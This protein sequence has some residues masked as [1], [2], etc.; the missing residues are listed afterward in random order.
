MWL[1][2]QAETREK[3][4]SWEK[5]LKE[6]AKDPIKFLYSRRDIWYLSEAEKKALGLTVWLEKKL[7]SI[8]KDLRWNSSFISNPVQIIMW[9][10]FSNL[11]YGAWYYTQFDK[12]VD[13]LDIRNLAK[14]DFNL[15]EPTISFTQLIKDLIQDLIPKLP[16]LNKKRT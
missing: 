5:V 4:L 12:D 15:S 1:S 13:F 11:N 2:F 9:I 3:E 8:F 14:Y 6:L 16:W 7:E 10:V